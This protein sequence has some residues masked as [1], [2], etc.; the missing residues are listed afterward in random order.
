MSGESDASALRELVKIPSLQKLYMPENQFFGNAG[1]SL[2]RWNSMASCQN[3]QVV[4]LRACGLSRGCG[5]DLALLINSIPNLTSIELDWNT[6]E[7]PDAA[8]VFSAFSSEHRSIEL[9]R[10]DEN[11][12]DDE[13]SCAVESFL[14]SRRRLEKQVK[15]DLPCCKVVLTGNRTTKEC[16]QT[17]KRSGFVGKDFIFDGL[18]YLTSGNIVRRDVAGML[19]RNKGNLYC[20]G[21]GNEG[22]F[23]IVDNLA[24]TSTI[25]VLDL[26]HCQIGDDGVKALATRALLTNASVRVLD[27]SSNRIGLQSVIALLEVCASHNSTL[28]A[29]GFTRNPAIFRCEKISSV[30]VQRLCRQVACCAHLKCLMLTDTG[31]SDD[32]AECLLEALRRNKTITFLGLGKNGLGD[33]T[34]ECL[35]KVAGSECG[36]MYVSLA[37]NNITDVGVGHLLGSPGV[38]EMACIWM[39]GNPCSV[40]SLRFPLVH[41]RLTYFPKDLLQFAK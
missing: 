5:N 19:E 16:L 35:A 4:R 33:K 39:K 37:E 1:L 36:L 6:L 26:K 11:K 9:V 8:C 13:V 12:I 41:G 10:L 3:L 2:M 24:S 30:G 21:I 14:K 18:F 7:T 28:C 20:Q 34:A 27:L 22:L 17:V 25:E 40:G 38:S 15:K 23:D 29:I 32:I 31:L